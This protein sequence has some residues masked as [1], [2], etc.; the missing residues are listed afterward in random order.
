MQQNWEEINLSSWQKAPSHRMTFW[1]IYIF[2]C[3]ARNKQKKILVLGSWTL[4]VPKAEVVFLAPFSSLDKEVQDIW[5]PVKYL[6]WWPLNFL[7]TAICFLELSKKDT[8]SCFH[9]QTL[10]SYFSSPN[11]CR[12]SPSSCKPCL[13]NLTSFELS[14]FSC[15]TKNSFLLPVYYSLFMLS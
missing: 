1:I 11:I 12:G 2:I 8:I 14:H 15:H 6:E 10:W 9:L 4:S 13:Q 7:D 5:W 3:W